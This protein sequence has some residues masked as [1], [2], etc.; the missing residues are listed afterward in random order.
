M[1]GR[2]IVRDGQINRSAY[3]E[4]QESEENPICLI[5]SDSTHVN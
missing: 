4:S 2:Y 5:A 1:R 3:R